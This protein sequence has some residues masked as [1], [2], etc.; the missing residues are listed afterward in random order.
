MFDNK[1][2]VN[3]P[4]TTAF[5]LRKS[6]REWMKKSNSQEFPSLR[7]S[8]EVAVLVEM[9][10]TELRDQ[11]SSKGED[12]QAI[13]DKVFEMVFFM[14]EKVWLHYELYTSQYLKSKKL[15]IALHKQ[16]KGQRGGPG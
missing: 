10:T 16:M 13:S 1:I 2:L 9:I 3:T 14:V 6:V 7:F 5:H 11:F 8:S 12:D 4:S 15:G